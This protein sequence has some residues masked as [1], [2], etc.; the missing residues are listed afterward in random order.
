MPRSSRLPLAPRPNAQA[1]Q[2]LSGIVDS[3]PARLKTAVQL[4]CLSINDLYTAASN[5]ELDK[6]SHGSDS[7]KNSATFANH[8]KLEALYHEVIQLLRDARG[9]VASNPTPANQ[10]QL[11]QCERLLCAWIDSFEPCFDPPSRTTH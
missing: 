9:A 11:M 8:I 5:C 1:A 7:K 4:L 3:K 2:A 6:K 10:R